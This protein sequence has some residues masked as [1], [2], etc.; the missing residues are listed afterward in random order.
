MCFPAGSFYIIVTVFSCNNSFMCS[1]QI[2][3]QSSKWR[4]YIMRKTCHKLS[5]CFLCLV[6]RRKFA[7]IGHNN[8]IDFIS[9][10]RDK[11]IICG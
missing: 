9:N 5:V 3:Y 2:P 8:L 10:R 1:V 4:S 7:L 11:L 6:K